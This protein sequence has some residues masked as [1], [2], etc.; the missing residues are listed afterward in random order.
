MA[1]ALV[2]A[3]GVIA[4]CDSMPPVDDP[5]VYECTDG[6]VAGEFV[7][8]FPGNAW[9]YE[10]RDQ[11]GNVDDTRRYRRV[12]AEIAD[13]GR[14]DGIVAYGVK[15]WR[16]DF[17]AYPDEWELYFSSNVGY[18]QGGRIVPGDTLR[19][20]TLLYPNPKIAGEVGHLIGFSNSELGNNVV[21]SLETRVQRSGMAL[22]TPAG[23]YS[24]VS[25]RVYAPPVVDSGGLGHYVDTFISPEFGIVGWQVRSAS[26]TEA[27]LYEEL[28]VSL[29]LMQPTG[30]Q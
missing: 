27:L 10:R 24:V 9:T 19:L 21:D 1:A 7:P 13:S 3:M 14:T 23:V 11:F 22:T 30:K 12:S 25:Y 15:V 18:F 16:G 28:L 20:S 5:I 6:P 17:T 8:L 26:A 4:S 2:A 29:C